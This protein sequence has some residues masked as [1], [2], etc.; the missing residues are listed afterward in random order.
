MIFQMRPGV[1][2]T[3]SSSTHT[4]SICTQ[5]EYNAFEHGDMY[6]VDA[7]YTDF[8]KLLPQ[9]QS[10]M[11]TYEE[12]QKALDEYAPI[13]EEK[14]KDQP[15]Y[16]PIDTHM[17]EDAY[18]DNGVS[19]PDE[20]NEERYSA[21]VDLGIMSVNDFDRVNECLEQYEENFITPS[22]DKMTIFGAY[23]YDG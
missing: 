22:G 18:T 6:F 11:Y 16:R 7:C 8:F 17:L 4:F 14:Y 5:N 15:W 21:R 9:R 10:C 20:V 12:L 3:N 19:N 2:E 23:G 13:C 1:F